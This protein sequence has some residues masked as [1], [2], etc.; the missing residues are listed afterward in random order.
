MGFLITSFAQSHQVD[1]LS[2]LA[3]PAFPE[4]FQLISPLLMISA[5]NSIVVNID[6]G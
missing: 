3:A 6:L 4:Y 1:Q 5:V 2:A